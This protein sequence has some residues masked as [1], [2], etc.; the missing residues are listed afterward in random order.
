MDSI[1]EKKRI[2][3]LS[4]YDEIALQDIKS[5]EIK[6]YGINNLKEFKLQ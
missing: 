4:K 6:Q 3:F 5:F 2:G 1:N